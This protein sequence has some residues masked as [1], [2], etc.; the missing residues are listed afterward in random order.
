LCRA[1]DKLIALEYSDGG[2]QQTAKD[3]LIDLRNLKRRLEVD[4]EIERI[5][6]GSIRGQ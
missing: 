4:A 3:M 6:E 2:T 5:R 1:L